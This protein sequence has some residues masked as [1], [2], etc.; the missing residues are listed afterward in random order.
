[1]APISAQNE[2]M[3]SNLQTCPL[4]LVETLLDHLP[5]APFFMKN[6]RLEFIAAND[7][8]LRLCG[9]RDRDDLIGRTSHDFFPAPAPQR[10][11]DLDRQVM[12]SGRALTDRLDLVLAPT[13][14]VWLL[15]SRSP[16]KD[17]W[18]K[19]AGVAAIARQLRTPDR[20][21]PAYKRMAEAITEMRENFER[22]LRLG[23]LAK[24]A[25]I[26]LAQFERDFSA[27]F[28][29]SPRQYLTKLRMEAAMTL[30]AGDQPI[31]A[32]AQDCG[33]ADQSAFTRRFV[34]SVGMTPS[35]YRK[36]VARSPRQTRLLPSS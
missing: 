26:S 24:R 31:S 22:P 21:A 25:R 1:M 33:Y 36:S 28:G 16:V 20:R 13:G 9:V 10:F 15:F 11:E 35:Q 29:V 17:E 34:A 8:M 3:T 30:L 12:R 23:E 4:G 6:T 32:V 2:M 18:G 27:L 7:A 19:I 14:P 5:D